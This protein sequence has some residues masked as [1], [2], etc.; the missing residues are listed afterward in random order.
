MASTP[1]A[2]SR[3]NVMHAVENNINPGA[4]QARAGH[5]IEI[6]VNGRPRHVADRHVTFEDVVQIAFPNDPTPNVVFSMTYRHA[7]S[8]PHAGEL[9]A[10]AS[11]EVKKGTSFNVTRTVQS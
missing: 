9:A 11:V 1:D 8:K 3:M 10:R 4:E 6:T 5:H 2:G 7:A